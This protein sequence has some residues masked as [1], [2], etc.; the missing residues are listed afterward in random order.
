MKRIKKIKPDNF[1]LYI[2][3]KKKIDFKQKDGKVYLIF[4]HNKPIEKFMRWLVKKPR[5]TDVELDEISSWVWL[6]IDGRNTV[7]SIGQL[8]MN[9]YGDKCEP[10]YER[11]TL[12]LRNLS[13]RGY[14]SFDSSLK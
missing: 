2:P 13:R 4:N 9:K 3:K 8:L 7:Y 6:Q 5:I 12:F 11:L 14:I 10:L 1:L